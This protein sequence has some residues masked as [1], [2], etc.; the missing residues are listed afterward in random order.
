MKTEISGAELEHNGD[1]VWI[2]SGSRATGAHARHATP[3]RAHA[4]GRERTCQVN[5]SL[6]KLLRIMLRV[7]HVIIALSGVQHAG[8]RAAPGQAER[9]VACSLLGEAQLPAGRQ[10]VLATVEEGIDVLIALR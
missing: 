10:V 4:A 6:G 7:C 9:I 3:R 5:E 1:S 2:F 8:G